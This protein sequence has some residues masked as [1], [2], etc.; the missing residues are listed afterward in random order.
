MLVLFGSDMS[1]RDIETVKLCLERAKKKKKSVSCDSDA[2]PHTGSP[3]ECNRLNSCK[4]K[5]DSNDQP[6]FQ[7]TSKKKKLSSRLKRLK[8]I[9]DR[10]SIL[11]EDPKLSPLYT[12]GLGRTELSK[13]TQP[14]DNYDSGIESVESN[15]TTDSTSPPHPNNSDT[16]TSTKHCAVCFQKLTLTCTCISQASQHCKQMKQTCDIE[17]NTIS[18]A[19]Y[20]IPSPDRIVAMDCEFVGVFP[21]D[22]SALGRCSIMDYN[23][24]VI[25]DSFI[26]PEG[27]IMTYRTRY[28]GIRKK[29]MKNAVPFKIAQ[30]Q[31]REILQDKVVVG[32]ALHNDFKVIKIQHS[33]KLVRD[34]ASY[35]PLRALANLS[36]R[37]PASLRTLTRILLG[38][39]IQ[40]KEHCSIEDSRAALDLYKLVRTGW[41]Q[42]IIKKKYEGQN[43]NINT[44]KVNCDVQKD[45]Y[46]E[47]ELQ[48]DLDSEENNETFKSFLNDEFWPSYLF[49]FDNN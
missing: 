6:I 44:A 46:N 12:G 30:K 5:H 49:P 45:E 48:C 16:C 28:S 47:N 2:K 10:R 27:T 18:L 34:T 33:G 19:S 31:I 3:D 39:S 8:C 37:T 20:N 7:P 1:E 29:D 4:R 32:H 40:G 24:N 42:L 38:R 17:V 35:K 21:K 43:I 9:K 25:Y 15:T 36:E 26:K 11:P 22:T 13:E 14:C 23:G 41:E